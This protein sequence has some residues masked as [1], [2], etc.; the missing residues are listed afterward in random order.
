MRRYTLNHV[1]VKLKVLVERESTHTGTR[2]KKTGSTLGKIAF[3]FSSLGQR[4]T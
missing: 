4:E 1:K 2:G 3:L